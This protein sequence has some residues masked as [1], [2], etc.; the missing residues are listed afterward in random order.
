MLNYVGLIYGVLIGAMEVTYRLK[1]TNT[2]QKSRK[3]LTRICRT[4]RNFS[5]E[6]PGFIGRILEGVGLLN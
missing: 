2:A 1:I 6:L 5:Y 3:T 4:N